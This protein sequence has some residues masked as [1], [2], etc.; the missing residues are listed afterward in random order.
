MISE[1][2]PTDIERRVLNGARQLLGSN[3][4]DYL[5]SGLGATQGTHC[6]AFIAQDASPGNDQV[7]R[8]FETRGDSAQGLPAGRDPVVMAALIGLLRERQPMDDAVAFDVGSMLETLGWPRNKES[9]LTVLRAVERYAGMTYCLVDYPLPEGEGA[10]SYFR[11][12]VISYET[13]SKPAA[14]KAK[15][16]ETAVRVQFWP[17]FVNSF[18]LARKSFLGVDFQTLLGIEE[19]HAERAELR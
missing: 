3:L 9:H 15:V 16:P 8:R 1:Y 12:L 5:L 7:A 14:A 4:A 11:R 18:A 10:G 2:N 6:R 13:V 19:A 17:Y